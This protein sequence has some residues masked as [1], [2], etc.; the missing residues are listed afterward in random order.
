MTSGFLRNWVIPAIVICGTSLGIG[1]TYQGGINRGVKKGVIQGREQGIQEGYV[2]GKND[3][4]MCIYDT[5]WNFIADDFDELGGALRAPA[6]T[7]E[8]LYA[9]DRTLDVLKGVGCFDD[10]SDSVRDKVFR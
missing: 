4:I 5:K 1:L 10:V 2:Q 8:D 6:H 3:A 7:T 9:L